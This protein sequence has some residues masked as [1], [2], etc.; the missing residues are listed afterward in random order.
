LVN[1]II[2]VVTGRDLEAFRLHSG[3]TSRAYI[4]KILIVVCF[5]LEGNDVKQEG[6]AEPFELP[7]A[8]VFEAPESAISDD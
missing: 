6:G 2:T 3:Y 5:P 7:E 4:Q 1:Y 8:D